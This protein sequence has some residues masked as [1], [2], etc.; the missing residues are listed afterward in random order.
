MKFILILFRNCSIVKKEDAVNG[1]SFRKP[2]DG[3]ADIVIDILKEESRDNILGTKRFG[4]WPL[5]RA[6]PS[7]SYRISSESLDYIEA[8]CARL[9]TGPWTVKSS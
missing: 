5:K 3:K 8:R 7:R 6:E 1:K 2:E 9:T 4:K